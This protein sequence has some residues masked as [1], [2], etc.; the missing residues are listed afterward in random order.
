MQNTALDGESF[1]NLTKMDCLELYSDMYGNRTNVLM[2]TED[3]P[4]AEGRSLLEYQYLPASWQH[5]DVY[6]PCGDENEGGPNCMRLSD[7]TQDVLN[8]WTRLN[9]PVLYCL[10]QKRTAEH[11]R[12]NYSPVIMI[13]ICESS[14]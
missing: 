11:C 14:L 9:H 2:V 5:T 8:H 3:I 4:G 7:A 12:L 6:W 1:L 13:G 10:S